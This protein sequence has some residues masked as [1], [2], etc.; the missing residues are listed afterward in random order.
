MDDEDAF[1]YGDSA[2]ATGEVFTTTAQA[3]PAQG[4][5]KDAVASSNNVPAPEQATASG[6]N[7]GGSQIGDE[8]AQGEVEEEEDEE[9]EEEDS[10]SDLEIIID[11]SVDAARPPSQSSQHQR[12]DR[13]Q[14]NRASQIALTDEYTPLARGVLPPRP[15]QPPSQ[16]IAAP[17]A[18]NAPGAAPSVPLSVAANRVSEGKQQEAPE[19]GEIPEGPPPHA[20][21]TAPV[22]RLTPSPEELAIEDGKPGDTVYHLD[23]TTMDLKPWRRAGT[24]LTDYFNYGFDE[25]SWKRWGEKKRRIIEERREFEQK[26]M[27]GWQNSMAHAMRGPVSSGAVGMNPF[28]AAMMGMSPGMPGMPGMSGMPGMPPGLPGMPGV[29]GMP[30]MPS[31]PDMATMAAMFG[32]MPPQM[33]QQMGGPEQMMAAMMGAGGG[34]PPGAMP[35]GGPHG[36]P[37][38]FGPPPSMDNRCALDGDSEMHGNEGE[39]NGREAGE[40][41]AP[42]VRAPTGPSARQALP[43][44]PSS[45]AGPFF[46]RPP[47]SGPA[48]DREKERDRD[49]LLPANVPTGPKGRRPQRPLRDGEADQLEREGSIATGGAGTRSR[50]ISERSPE[51]EWP[52]SPGTGGRDHDRDISADHGTGS[53]SR[54]RRSPPS[55][56]ASRGRD[57]REGSLTPGGDEEN[58]NG[59]RRSGAGRNRD[60]ERAERRA[61]RQHADEEQLNYDDD[62]VHGSALAPGSVAGTGKPSSR[63][64]GAA[65]EDDREYRTN[66]I[67]R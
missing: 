1:L 6:G 49:T 59:S 13:N 14:Q 53:K 12:Y 5:E 62:S 23:P 43:S 66:K 46:D 37:G 17:E 67:R 33:Q 41:S 31:I 38:H 29:P 3:P 57:S 36:G 50:R 52:G 35:F 7:A 30:G 39:T 48:A 26:R 56:P 40:T 47:P 8:D 21:S 64:R 20:P 34:G 58:G 4:T 44:G 55:P 11:N 45:G 61:G 10:D 28:A 65:E 60:R 32:Q 25:E 24:D 15:G 42:G 51:M 9:G 2:G 27:E 22:L 16:L 54:A 19:H 18:A 63:K